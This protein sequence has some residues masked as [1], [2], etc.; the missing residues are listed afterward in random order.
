MRLV[1]KLVA[2]YCLYWPFGY[3]T[4]SFVGIVSFH[5]ALLFLTSVESAMGIGDST[6]STLSRLWAAPT[7]NLESPVLSVGQF[8][9]CPKRPDPFCSRGHF[10]LG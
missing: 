10:M 2:C 8:F 5:Y 9:C 1:S 4:S 7:T 6:V 3:Q